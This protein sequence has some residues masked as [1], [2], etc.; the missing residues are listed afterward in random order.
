[1][2]CKTTGSFHIHINKKYSCHLDLIWN[3]LSTQSTPV[4]PPPQ[5]WIKKKKKGTHSVSK[6][7]VHKL[8]RGVSFPRS[9]FEPGVCRDGRF[10]A[11]SVVVQQLFALVDVPRGD[12]DEVRDAVDVV[13]FG[14]AVPVFTVIDQPTHSASL[15]RGVHAVRGKKRGKKS[16]TLTSDLVP[17]WDP[18]TRHRTLHYWKDILLDQHIPGFNIQHMFY[19]TI[20][21]SGTWLQT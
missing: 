10:T 9:V 13:Q 16:A 14:L 11:V 19:F 2:C 12:E 1:M 3:M 5:Y 18:M 17:R 8:T 15:F 21:M 7:F 4:C 20:K 6:A